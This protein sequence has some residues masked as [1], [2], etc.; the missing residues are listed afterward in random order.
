MSIVMKNKLSATALAI[1]TVMGMGYSAMSSAAVS[2]AD[3]TAQLIVH[4]P[5]T[6]EPE[7]TPPV[8]TTWASTWTLANEA[9][10][11]GTIDAT[12]F[13]QEP[14]MIKVALAAGASTTC[15]LNGLVVGASATGGDVTDVAGQPG[16]YQV[17]TKSGGFWRYVPT[18]AQAHF[19]TDDA[20]QTLD[21]GAITATLGQNTATQSAT[22]LY[23]KGTAIAGKAAFGTANALGVSDNYFA[24][25]GIAPITTAKD[26]KV[27]SATT[28]T[29]MKSAEIGISA[30]IANDPVDAGGT[31]DTS[32]VSNAATINMPFT[33]E[34][35][36]R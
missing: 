10:A 3:F 36:Y 11:S 5:N 29:Q 20:W 2:T 14:H 23:T 26:V 17:D 31:V 4:S 21:T 33:V 15:D 9:D 18:I 12:Q 6:C 27:A 7:L 13:P 24:A 34:V 35:G 30:V 32:L 28:G 1:A 16:Y 8:D 25:D 22:A 19:Y